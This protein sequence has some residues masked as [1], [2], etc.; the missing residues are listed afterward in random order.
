MKA[1]LVYAIVFGLAFVLVTVGIIFMN[2]KYNNIFKFDF[3]PPQ[4][5]VVHKAKPA[6]PKEPKADSL[7]AEQVEEIAE[8]P[9]Q[10]LIETNVAETKP[11]KDS[12][13]AKTKTTTALYDSLKILKAKVAML[14]KENKA[15]KNKAK[16][17][18]DLKE[19][20]RKID[21][22][23]VASLGSKKLEEWAKT[24][25][26]LYESMDPKKAAKII[27]SYSDNESREILFKMNKKK[28]AKVLSELDP[29]IAHRITKAL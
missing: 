28:A 29:E 10:D 5:L 6:V 19:Q 14:E 8:P 20:Q 1:K 15:A 21:S 3:R 7:Q 27:Q 16:S 9:A 13:V 12:V 22:A 11:K 2:S 24:T 4:P 26:K 18:I 23:R 25:A 17:N